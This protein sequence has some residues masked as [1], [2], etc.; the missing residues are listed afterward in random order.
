LRARTALIGL[1]ALTLLTACGSGIGMRTPDYTPTQTGR[2]F[3][4]PARDLV[5]GGKIVEG[6]GAQFQTFLLNWLTTLA[7]SLEVVTSTS[8]KLT[9]EEPADVA[10][11]LE[12]AAASNADRALV[13]VLGNMRD[14]AAMSFRTDF[15]TIQ[16]GSLVTV[17]ENKTLW[18]VAGYELAGTN[19]RKYPTLLNGIAKLVA[20]NITGN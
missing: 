12:E 4:A 6:S 2:L 1:A 15:V 18:S 19:V 10:V 3:L 7:P 9:H 14:A 8:G 11:V 17:P 13:I 20:V 5:H 16:T